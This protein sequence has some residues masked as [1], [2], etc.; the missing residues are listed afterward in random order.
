MSMMP[1]K[2]SDCG[3]SR[4]SWT[5]MSANARYA[6]SLIRK[7]QNSLNRRGGEGHVVIPGSPWGEHKEDDHQTKEDRDH[8]CDVCTRLLPGGTHSFS[9]IVCD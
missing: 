9:K 4:K 2:G 8:R 1:V 6:D 7:A 3:E 5:I